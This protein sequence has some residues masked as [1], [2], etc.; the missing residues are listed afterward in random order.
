MRALEFRA[1]DTKRKTYDHEELL[2]APNGDILASRWQELCEPESVYIIEPFIGLKD[3]NGQKIYKGDIVTFM[4][5]RF[6]SI[7]L[8]F[9]SEQWHTAV[10]EWNQDD[11][12]YSFMDGDEPF[13]V[14][15]EVEVIGN[16]H[17]NKEILET[18][19]EIREN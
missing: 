9:D 15:Y 13:S 19:N 14:Q 11:A 16:I 12:C 5:E 8:G 4:V 10:V 3:K 6:D 1:W 2:L 18:K 17:E 7:T